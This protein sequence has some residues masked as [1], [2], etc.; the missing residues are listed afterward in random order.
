M[1]GAGVAPNQQSVHGGCAGIRAQAAAV[2]MP[3]PG[4]ARPAT[5]GGKP[6]FRTPHGNCGRRPTFFPWRIRPGGARRLAMAAHVSV[7]PRAPRATVQGRGDTLDYGAA[8]QGSSP[9]CTATPAAPGPG[10]R[11][12]PRMSSAP[13]RDPETIMTG[14]PLTPT[15]SN[16]GNP[17]ARFRGRGTT[18]TAGSD[19]G[20]TSGAE[21]GSGPD[22]SGPDAEEANRA[23]VR[24]RAGQDVRS[25]PATRATSTGYP[26]AHGPC[27]HGADCTALGRQSAADSVRARWRAQAGRHVACRY[28]A[29]PGRAVMTWVRG[30]GGAIALAHA[31]ER[32]NRIRDPPRV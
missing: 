23:D 13:K 19:T 15:T 9:T 1:R 25:S 12:T 14:A 20:P 28:G 30:A 8:D 27:G 4:I 16:A 32:G 29:T 22:P 24:R 6:P 17:P 5:R 10:M 26:P 18:E 11:S 2:W 3:G 31:V 7:S 21:A